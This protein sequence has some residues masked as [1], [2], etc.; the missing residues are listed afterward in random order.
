MHNMSDAEILNRVPL[1]AGLERPEQEA[2]ARGMRRRAYK[3]GDVLF[4]RDDPGSLLY[5]IISGHVRI[6]LPTGTGDEVTLDVMKPGE[7]FGELA[8]FDELPRSASA[9]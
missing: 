5:C 7:V 9:M 6:Y 1:F 2:L 4:H 3:R 8:V